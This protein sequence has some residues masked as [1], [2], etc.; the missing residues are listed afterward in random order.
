MRTLLVAPVDVDS[1]SGGGD[2]PDTS[3][4]VQHRSRRREDSGVAGGGIGGGGGGIVD[5]NVVAGKS[6]RHHRYHKD[7]GLDSMRSSLTR[8]KTEHDRHENV[9][10]LRRDGLENLLLFKQK[11]FES[12]LPA[13]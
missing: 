5:G 2:G 1:V 4:Q 6:L 11:T 12:S 7:R 3:E 9:G 10:V 8:N 13:K